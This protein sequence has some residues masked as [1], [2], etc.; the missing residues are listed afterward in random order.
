[1][2]RRLVSYGLTMASLMCLGASAEAV[3]K[4]GK[5]FNMFEVGGGRT[6]PIGSY[7]HIGIISFVDESGMTRNLDADQVFDPSYSIHAAFGQLRSRVAAS[8]GIVYTKVNQLDTFLV[9]ENLYYFGPEGAPVTPKFEQV[10]LRL[11]CNYHL[12]D[13][14]AS[15]FSPY[16]GV[17]A[18]VG[19]ISQ[20]APGYVTE[21]DLNTLVSVNFGAEFKV[22]S[23]V[24][25]RT[26][27]TLAS[28]NS[29]DLLSSGYRPRFLNIGGAIRFYGRP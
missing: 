3:T 28:V 11:N 18:A 8:V 24:D 15:N 4:V 7:D 29:Y 20:S 19:M 5:R 12:L 1:M 17:G 9:S 13:L 22:W 27:L 6:T 26:F 21:Y 16:V 14:S 25:K 10:D 2:L 23:S